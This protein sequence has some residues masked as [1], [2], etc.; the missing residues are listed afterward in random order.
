MS[1]EADPLAAMVIDVA[2]PCALWQQAQPDAAALVETAARAALAGSGAVLATEA[3]LAV[4]LAD[5]ATVRAL[6]QRW[7]GQDAPTNVLSFA[8]GDLSGGPQPQL[9][10]DVVLAFETVAR[11]AT[12][13]HK[14]LADHLRHLTVHGVLHL[15][16]FDHMVDAEAERMEALERRILAGLGIADPYAVR[17]E[18][19][20]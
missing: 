20:G 10:G 11:E 15:L 7:R 13:Q 14:S 16:G 2:L 19:D 4:V 17:E 6:N 9:L 18:A 3:E 1:R 8:S 5:D 12:A